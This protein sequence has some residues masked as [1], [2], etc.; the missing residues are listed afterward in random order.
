MQVCSADAA[1][2]TGTADDTITFVDGQAVAG[3][4]V[5]VVSDGTSWFAFA[6][7]RVAAGITFTQ[8][9]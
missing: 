6:F 9:S 1:G 7:S 2:D 4:R 8:A 3:D 5:D